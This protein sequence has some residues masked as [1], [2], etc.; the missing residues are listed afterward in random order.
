MQISKKKKTELPRRTEAPKRAADARLAW[1]AGSEHFAH[2]DPLY[3]V[4]EDFQQ[5]FDRI[6]MKYSRRAAG[7]EE[8]QGAETED[9][10]AKKEQRKETKKAPGEEETQTGGPMLWTGNVPTALT[11][12]SETAFRR[13]AMSAIE[14][15]TRRASRSVS[16]TMPSAPPAKPRLNTI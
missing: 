6:G 13:G 4:T 14:S 10:D 1:A 7:E 11:A 15:T 9:R 3:H 12:F 5:T 2:R 8:T 16:T